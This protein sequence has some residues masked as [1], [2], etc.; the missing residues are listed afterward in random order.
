VNRELPYGPPFDAPRRRRT[1]RPPR[2]TP[3][4]RVLLAV[5]CLAVFVASI[6]VGLATIA[7]SH[8]DVPVIGPPPVTP[9]TACAEDQPCWDC[10]VD[11]NRRCGGPSTSDASAGQWNEY[12]DGQRTWWEFD[13][14]AAT[15]ANGHLVEAA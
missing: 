13:R 7:L 12:A 9:V 3:R 10:H 8:R 2:F 11:G 4:E 5:A 6:V 1:K 14:Y 15:D